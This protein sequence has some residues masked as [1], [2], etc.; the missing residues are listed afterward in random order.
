MFCFICQHVSRAIVLISHW[1]PGWIRRMPRLTSACLSAESDREVQGPATARWPPL[2]TRQSFISIHHWTQ[3]CAYR[4]TGLPR[5][6]RRS[7]RAEAQPSAAIFWPCAPP[8][9]RLVITIFLQYLMRHFRT[10]VLYWDFRFFLRFILVLHTKI[11][12]FIKCLK[13]TEKGW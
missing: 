5:T 1:F 12:N 8:R 6:A 11:M 2:L 4:Q 10:T 13:K 7:K 3:L 9:G